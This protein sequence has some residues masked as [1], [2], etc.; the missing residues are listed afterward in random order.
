MEPARPTV[1]D[2]L[3]RVATDARLR[4]AAE[5][6]TTSHE[7]VRR[8]VAGESISSAMDVAQWLGVRGRAVSVTHLVAEPQDGIRIEKRVKRIRK[9]VRR[10]A[11]A[12]LATDGGA[13]VSVRLSTL[14][15]GLGA[16]GRAGA[17]DR[18]RE[19]AEIGDAHGVTLT[20]EV[21]D[22][23]P[24]DVTFAAFHEVRA[25]RPTLG[26]SVP[27]CLRRAEA[28]CVALAATGARVRL[29]KGAPGREE[30]AFT[31]RSEVDR[32]YV[33]AVQPLLEGNGT[34][35]VATHDER[36][37]RLAE[38]LARHLRRPRES[39]EYQLRYGVR[40]DKQAEIADRGDTLRV[41]VPFGEDWYPY[42]ARRVA[43]S[44]REILELVRATVF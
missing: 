31:R 24:P 10:L 4:R 40:P 38:T 21:E 30:G 17:R 32:A 25:E 39:V 41:Y 12:G 36:L 42:L 43:D 26:I 8:Y 1:Q 23:V 14:G 11:D 15:A 5:N 3:L 37:I 16:A 22:L 29:T 2:V 20:L 18:L 7:I 44:P 13:D 28:D 27:A 35:V 6:R 9:L 34:V 19:L 33:R